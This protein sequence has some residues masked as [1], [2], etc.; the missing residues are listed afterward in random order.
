M[1]IANRHLNETHPTQPLDFT[2][3]W[4]NPRYG[5]PDAMIED[6]VNSAL[7]CCCFPCAVYRDAEDLEQSGILCCLLSCLAP[8]LSVYFLRRRARDMFNIN[9]DAVEDCVGATCCPVCVQCQVGTE[10]IRRGARSNLT[11]EAKEA[12]DNAQKAKRVHDYAQQYRNR[13]DS[14]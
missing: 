8:C 2:M 13:N 11:K 5:I 14:D 6:P 12:K 10:L 7:V 1:G 4:K 9:G 3:G